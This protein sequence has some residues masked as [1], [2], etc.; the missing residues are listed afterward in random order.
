MKLEKFG[1]SYWLVSVPRGQED[2]EGDQVISDMG[3][4]V[5]K[6]LVA[7]ISKFDVPNFRIGTYDSLMT[8][9]DEL[10]KVDIYVEA[11]LKKISV[12]Y[13]KVTDKKDDLVIQVNQTQ[14][15]DFLYGFSWDGNQ[16]SVRKP[17]SELTEFI[18]SEV[19]KIEEDLRVKTQ[20]YTTVES[21]LNKATK[22]ESG[23]LLTKDLTNILAKE[24]LIETDYMTTILVVIPETEQKTFLS[25]YEFFSEG[26]LPQSAEVINDDGQFVLYKVVC[27]KNTEKKTIC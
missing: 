12:Q 8:L 26:V 21:I 23:S 13:W 5:K 20:A 16:Y 7:K 3:N 1:Q 25:K 4:L 27:F 18:Q 17:L 14:P 2:E 24:Q 22:D 15:D 10:K 9:S 11:Q 19:G 6:G